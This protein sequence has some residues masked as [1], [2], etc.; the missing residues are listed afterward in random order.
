L[1]L[2]ENLKKQLLGEP[3]DRAAV[4]NFENLLKASFFDGKQVTLIPKMTGMLSI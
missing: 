1:E 4:R 3:Q 2:Y